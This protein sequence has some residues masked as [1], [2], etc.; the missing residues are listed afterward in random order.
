MNLK[1]CLSL[2][3][4]FFTS[5]LCADFL[6]EYQVAMKLNPEEAAPRFLALAEKSKGEAKEKALF[7]AGENYIRS[8]KYAEADKIAMQIQG[9]S[10]KFLKMKI[11]DT[12]RKYNELLE[13]VQEENIDT[14]PDV[15]QFDAYQLRGTAFFRKGNPEKAL[16]DFRKTFPLAGNELQKAS[17]LNTC[18]QI[19]VAQ[20]KENEAVAEFRKVT[21]LSSIRGYGQFNSAHI[22]IANILL[23]KKQYD[24]ALAELGKIPRAKSG[25]W[26]YTPLLEE[27]KVLKLMGKNAEAD[28]KSKEANALKK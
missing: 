25:Y 23:A 24:Q 16:A 20:N 7:R 3:M 5:V 15:L 13:L 18:G 4:S 1:T 11:L 14:W 12:Q 10:S 9:T 26:A 2:A 22:S 28:A 8:R 17:I 21:E 19:L 6:E 27:A